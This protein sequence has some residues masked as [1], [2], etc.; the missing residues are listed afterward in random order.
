MKSSSANYFLDIFTILL[1]VGLLLGLAQT[2]KIQ[3]LAHKA[4]ETR[5]YSVRLAEELRHSSRDLTTAARGY[6]TTEDAHFWDEFF[7][8]LARRNGTKS[9]DDGRV[10]PLR[11]LIVEAG[12]TPEE[13][14]LLDTAQK[15]SNDL[16]G[17]EIGA[18]KEVK[19]LESLPQSARRT[20]LKNQAINAVHGLSYRRQVEQI[21]GPISH[22]EDTVDQRTK[23]EAEKSNFLLRTMLIT[24]TAAVL[25]LSFIIYLQARFKT[26][27]QK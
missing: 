2:L 15:V 5:F 13:L 22:F 6:V 10:I 20:S 21:M 24:L 12:F 16:S 18:M 3:G 19:G 17:I 1:L 26:K 25:I 4:E 7:L 14:D 23:A 9:R 11:A 27:P 8:I